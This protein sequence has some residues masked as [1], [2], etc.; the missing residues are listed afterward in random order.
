MLKL[1]VMADVEGWAYDRRAKAL[2]KYSPDHWSVDIAYANHLGSIDFS[3]YDVVFN[4]EYWL[5]RTIR[6]FVQNSGSEAVLVTSHNAD[7]RRCH[8]LFEQSYIVSDFIILNNYE[9]FVHFEKRD[10]TCNISNGVDFEHFGD[11][12]LER[13]DAAVWTGSIQKGYKEILLPLQ[14]MTKANL[15]LHPVDGAGWD[16]V[17]ANEDKV[18]PTSRMREWYNS[19]KVVLCCS[20]TEATPNYLLEGMACGLVPVTT[21]VGNAMEFGVDGVNCKFC[22]R[23]LRSLA[24]GIDYAIAN[25]DEMSKAAVDTI[26]SW[27]WHERSKLF[28]DL[29]ER[30]VQKENVKPFSY[31][32]MK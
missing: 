13:T 4:I 1:L 30:L 26:S 24:E 10:R 23:T 31:K 7:H 5:S 9:A 18:W 32:D 22:D 6:Q 12:G 16:G 8:E 25:Y 15:L 2:R 17:K 14:E 3:K 27:G 11:D 21:R 19:A 20:E 28:F 29:F